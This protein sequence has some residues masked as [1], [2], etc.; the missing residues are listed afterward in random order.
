MGK[1]LGIHLGYY[2]KKYYEILGAW[3]VQLGKKQI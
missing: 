3:V 2:D 1:K